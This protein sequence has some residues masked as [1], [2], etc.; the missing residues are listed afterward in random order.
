MADANSDVLAIAKPIIKE[1]EEFVS[2]PYLCPAG[3]WTI[4]WG[5]TRYPS[6]KSVLPTDYPDGIPEDFANVC[7]VSAMIRT[8]AS[9]APLLKHEPTANQAAALLSLAYNIGVGVHDGI[10]GDLAD[11]T[12]LDKFNAGDVA[13]AADQF[14]VW[15]K[16]HV[17]GVLKELNGLKRRRV[18]ERTLFL[19]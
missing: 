5:T 18:A 19:S 6:G 7:L 16:A 9:L 1:F 17:D 8:R 4:G 13:G 10:K 11:S 14:L 12:L 2:T 3:K 15:D